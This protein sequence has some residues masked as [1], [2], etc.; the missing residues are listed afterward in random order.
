VARRDSCLVGSVVSLFP[1]ESWRAATVAWLAVWFL[2][3]LL[4]CG[5]IVQKIVNRK[6]EI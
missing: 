5:T 3:F 1:V 6:S 2:Y 4:S